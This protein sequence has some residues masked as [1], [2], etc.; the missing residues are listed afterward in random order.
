M[1]GPTDQKLLFELSKAYL[2][3]QS[4]ERQK[5]P[6]AQAEELRRRGGHEPCGAGLG[7]KL[8]GVSEP[9]TAV[10]VRRSTCT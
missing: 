10:K 1:Y 4:A 9:L 5:A 3:A 7:L 8:I 2:N 6:A